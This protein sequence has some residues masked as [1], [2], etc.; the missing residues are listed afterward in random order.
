MSGLMEKARQAQ[1]N[2]LQSQRSALQA[3][4][5]EGVVTGRDLITF[6]RGMYNPSANGS[7]I[8][9]GW[10]R[11]ARRV[12]EETQDRNADISRLITEQRKHTT[13]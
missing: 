12:H 1:Q 6:R 2:A 9:E 13:G 10:C 3:Q 5:A 11:N 4:A 8:F 7:F